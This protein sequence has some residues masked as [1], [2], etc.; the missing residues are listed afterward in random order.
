MHPARS[1]IAALLSAVRRVPRV[2]SIDAVFLGVVLTTF[3]VWFYSRWPLY[4]DQSIY[5]YMAW[6]ALHGMVPYRDA[7]NMNWPGIVPFHILGRLLTGH[8]EAGF[9]LVD[10]VVVFVLGVSSA[11]V[12]RAGGTPAPIRLLALSLYLLAYSSSSRRPPS[13]SRSFAES[14]SPAARSSR[15]ARRPAWRS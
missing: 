7:I 5:H 13:S 4:I 12:L 15:R 9:R 1:M 6:G 10:T 2:L 11:S 3:Y 8:D 14:S